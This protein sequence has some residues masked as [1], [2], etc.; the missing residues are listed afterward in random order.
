MMNRRT[1]SVPSFRSD[2]GDGTNDPGSD[3]D[4]TGVIVRLGQPDVRPC[5]SIA[6]ICAVAPP[7]RRHRAG[8]QAG[9][10]FTSDSGGVPAYSGDL[11]TYS[12]GWPAYVGDLSAYVGDLPAHWADVRRA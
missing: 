3:M 2:R 11:P 8:G 10:R 4:G 6:G 12:G 1:G 7:N 5:G 9:Q